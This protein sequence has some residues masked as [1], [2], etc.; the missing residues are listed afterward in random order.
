M[1]TTAEQDL[2]RGM[3]GGAVPVRPAP[4]GIGPPRCLNGHDLT[5]ATCTSSY[6]HLYGL[7]EISCNVC[8]EL[9]DPRS[10]WCL[11]DPAKQHS[12]DDAPT[13]GLALV[14]I[15]PVERGGVGQL[16]LRIDGTVHADLD[17][18]VCGPCRRAVLEHVRSDVP[19]RGYGRVLVAAAL[20]LAPPSDYRWSTTRVDDTVT[21]RAFWATVGWPGALGQPDYCSDM[22]RAAGRLPDW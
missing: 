22:E 5:I 16:Q 13:P 6:H 14:R 20:A 3:Y 21:A 17:L 19:R 8:F 15:P 12:A 18:A 11:V 10:K 9:H 4:R 1:V 2:A 7:T